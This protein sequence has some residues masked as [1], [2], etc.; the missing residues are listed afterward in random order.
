[1]DLYSL[2]YLVPNDNRTSG[3]SNY[4]DSNETCNMI[5]KLL[6]YFFFRIAHVFV[7]AVGVVY[8]K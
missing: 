5:S 1:M 7:L 8:S 4:D 2:V 3:K 6:N